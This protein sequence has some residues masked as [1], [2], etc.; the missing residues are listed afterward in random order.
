MTKILRTQGATDN[1]ITYGLLGYPVLMTADIIMFN[2]DYVPVGVD[3]VAHIEISRD[4][5][6]R[7]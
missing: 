1:S 4:I 2:S 5:I 6:R 3:Q 7:F